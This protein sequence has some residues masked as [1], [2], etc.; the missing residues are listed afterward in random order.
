MNKWWIKGKDKY[1][2]WW[3]RFT[4]ESD[5]WKEKG[6]LEN[7]KKAI[8]EFE[9]EYRRDIEDI[10]RQEREEEIFR[11]RELLG[12]FTVRKLFEWSDKK[13]DKE[14]WIRLERNWRR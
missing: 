4:V 13:Y 9:K 8:E 1:L 6:N 2:V 5:T 7:A 11:R 12:R 3:K 14:Y 10:R